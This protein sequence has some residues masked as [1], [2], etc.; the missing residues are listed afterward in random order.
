[1][2]VEKRIEEKVEVRRQEKTKHR[3]V[4]KPTLMETIQSPYR[5]GKVIIIQ[6]HTQGGFRGF[7]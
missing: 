6:G 7:R 4:M 2:H 5:I 3:R 1:M